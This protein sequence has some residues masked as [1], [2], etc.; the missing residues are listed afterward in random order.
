VFFNLILARRGMFAG[1]GNGK[2]RTENVNDNCAG[3]GTWN[4]NDRTRNDSLSLIILISS[5]KIHAF[6]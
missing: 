1:R 4:G 6:K 3:R 2:G 5:R